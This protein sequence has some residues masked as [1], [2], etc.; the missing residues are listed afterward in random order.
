MLVKYYLPVNEDIDFL[1]GEGSVK[2]YNNKLHLAF[3]SPTNWNYLVLRYVT[4]G[5]RSVESLDDPG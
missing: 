1:W 5:Q 3:T 4:H 2:V